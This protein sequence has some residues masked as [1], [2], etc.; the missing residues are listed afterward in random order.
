[1][2]LA[3]IPFSTLYWNTGF[4]FLP[5]CRVV[6]FRKSALYV[7]SATMT[8]SNLLVWAISLSLKQAL[9]SFT[10]V[11][12]AVCRTIPS[13][14]ATFW[15]GMSTACTLIKFRRGTCTTLAVAFC[16]YLLQSRNQLL[17]VTTCQQWVAWSEECHLCQCEFVCAN[18][19]LPINIFIDIWYMCMCNK[20][21]D[22]VSPMQQQR[23]IHVW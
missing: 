5:L 1:M 18:Y 6:V 10:A 11:T 2:C 9:R 4:S 17:S 20:I 14:T 7:S 13:T 12:F 23:N 21:V 16:N 15:Q 19:L 3:L 8:S 22:S